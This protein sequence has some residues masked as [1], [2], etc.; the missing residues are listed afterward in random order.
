MNVSL[1]E[2][3]KPAAD[4]RTLLLISGFIWSGVGIMLVSFALVWL[5]A[6]G[7]TAAY[8]LGGS[9]LVLS[10]FIHHFGLTRIV[11]RNLG[12]ILPVRDKRCLFSFQP[13]KSYIIILIMIAMGVTLRHSSFPKP[14]LAVIY[15][16][17]GAALILSS[18]RYWK[19]F[20]RKS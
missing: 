1:M 16:A 6:R 12:R 15:M 17:M 3:Y 10:W 19:H 7:G 13:W 18:T 4:R 20:F 5:S 14:Y 11:N 8:L 2:R 9:G